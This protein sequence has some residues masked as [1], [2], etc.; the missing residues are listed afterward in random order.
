MSFPDTLSCPLS[1]G[2]CNGSACKKQQQQ[3]PLQVSA[4]E[5]W[6]GALVCL[7]EITCCVS[8]TPSQ[9]GHV[10]G[11]SA[12]RETMAHSNQPVMRLRSVAVFCTLQG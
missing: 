4:L 1:A 11:K 5:M 7:A 8:E 12:N 3:A 9:A 10:A 6:S 2:N